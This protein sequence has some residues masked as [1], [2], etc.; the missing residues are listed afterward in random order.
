MDDPSNTYRKHIAHVMEELAHWAKMKRDSEQ[1]IAK[2][3][4]LVIANANMLPDDEERRA[5]ISHANELVSLGFTDSIRELFRK[6]FPKGLTPMGVRDGLVIDGW[7]LSSQV[8]PMASIHSV[9][10]RMVA[11]GE[12]E[13]DDAGETGSY[14]CRFGSFPVPPV[15]RNK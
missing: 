4:A 2:L 8:N 9:I 12:I 5:F 10:R 3:R 7:D 6:V 15:S 1:Q 14:R 11:A 13:P